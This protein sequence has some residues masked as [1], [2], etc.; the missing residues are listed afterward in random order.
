MDC[1]KL[2]YKTILGHCFLYYL[3]VYPRWWKLRFK[4]KQDIQ[5]LENKDSICFLKVLDD[6][7]LKFEETKSILLAIDDQMEAIMKVQLGSQ[8]NKDFVKIV[9]K[10]LKIYEKYGGSFLWGNNQK[11]EM[12]IHQ[13][14]AIS[15]HYEE[16][17]L[18]MTEEEKKETGTL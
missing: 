10:E 5:T 4:V 16:K 2:P 12:R 3:I 9:T 13:E 1:N 8:S 17:G 18:G 7:I 6:I 15:A 14:K 11:K